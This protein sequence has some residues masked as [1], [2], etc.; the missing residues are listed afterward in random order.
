MGREL[1]RKD[2][3]TSVPSMIDALL[4][5][6]PGGIA[7]H[8]VRNCAIARQVAVSTVLRLTV[9]TSQLGRW[10]A[11]VRASAVAQLRRADTAVLDSGADPATSG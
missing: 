5:N 9:L 10:Q 2:G 8:C 1:A 4:Y 6:L 3:K 7:M 11:A